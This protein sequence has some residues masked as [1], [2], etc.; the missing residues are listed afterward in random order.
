MEVDVQSATVCRYED[1][2]STLQTTWR[3]LTNPWDIRPQPMKGYDIVGTEGA[4]STRERAV[5]IRVTTEEHPEGYVVNP[6]NSPTAIGTL[7]P[8]SSTALTKM[9]TPK[10]Q[11]AR[12]LP[13]S[14]ADNRDRTPKRRRRTDT[15]PGGVT[16]PTACSSL[17]PARAAACVYSDRSASRR[18]TSRPS[19]A[20]LYAAI[21]SLRN[22]TTVVQV[23]QPVLARP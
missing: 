14:P 22:T 5:P 7:L 17:A 10:D 20:A 15:Q 8:I 9:L 12:V 6:T 3:M 16:I 13:R 1:G 21:Q 11:A 2:L 19:S 4:I 18:F 23:K